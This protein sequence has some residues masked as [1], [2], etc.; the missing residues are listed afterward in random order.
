[1][2]VILFTDPYDH[3]S[4]ALQLYGIMTQVFE[5]KIKNW[6]ERVSFYDTIDPVDLL[7]AIGPGDVV[8]I[9]YGGLGPDHDSDSM[10]MRTERLIRKCIED[11]PSTQFVFIL[12]MG[13]EYYDMSMF[14]H[15]NVASIDRGKP[16]EAWAK[17]FKEFMEGDDDRPR[18][19]RKGARRL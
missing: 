5:G 6:R 7:G 17:F 1:M 13:P 14:D 12:T 10:Y 16:A 8:F 4:D 9:D 19:K 3:E 18:G 15:H 11:F 2:R